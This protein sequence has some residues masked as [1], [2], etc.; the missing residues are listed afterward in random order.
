MPFLVLPIAALAMTTASCLITSTPDFESPEQTP[1]FLLSQNATPDPR[2]IIALENPKGSLTFSAFVRSEDGG[3]PVQTRLLVNYGTASSPKRPYRFAEIGTTLG[4][5]SMD[6]RSRVASG[7]FD[8][9]S[10]NLVG[11]F[12]FTLMVS[13]AFDDNNCPLD[14]SDSD[15]ITW[16]AYLCESADNCAPPIDP[17][18]DCALPPDPTAC[19]QFSPQATSSASTSSGAAQ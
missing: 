1:P 14:L 6:D 13:H 17:D 2:E 7:V 18:V 11:C 12:R 16:T 9:A 8:N 3:E 19:P 10:Y 4:P 5:S 15:A